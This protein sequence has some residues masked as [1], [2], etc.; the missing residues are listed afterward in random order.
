MRDSKDDFVKLA[1]D[2]NLYHTPADKALGAV[3]AHLTLNLNISTAEAAKLLRTI[4]AMGRTPE[5]AAFCY[6]T[7]ET[8]CELY[9]TNS[10]TAFEAVTRIASYLE[11]CAAIEEFEACVANSTPPP[12]TN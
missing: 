2:M 5:C 1:E 4:P 3:V 12:T 7:M 8:V 9:G 11:K 6:T 10:K